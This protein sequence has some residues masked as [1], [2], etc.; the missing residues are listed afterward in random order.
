M[1]SESESISILSFGSDSNRSSSY[2]LLKS[3]SSLSLYFLITRREGGMRTGVGDMQRY[4][5]WHGDARRNQHRIN[6]IGHNWRSSSTAAAIATNQQSLGE[7]SLLWEAWAGETTY[8]SIQARWSM[9]RISDREGLIRGKGQFSL[10]FLM[11]S[12]ARQGWRGGVMRTMALYV[13]EVEREAK[14]MLEQ[15]ASN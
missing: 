10:N 2:S 12:W 6:R 11:P 4:G 14:K 15:K 1:E 9:E 7:G 8:A 3:L 5:K 13:E